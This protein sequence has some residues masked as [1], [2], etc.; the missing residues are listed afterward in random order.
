MRKVPA[1]FFTVALA[2][3]AGAAVF[4]SC[5]E[6]KPNDA[7]VAI[8][9]AEPTVGPEAGSQFLLVDAEGDWTVSVQDGCTWASLSKTSGSGSGN[10]VLS[11]E[12]N[13]TEGPRTCGIEARSAG[14]KYRSKAELL[15]QADSHSGGHENGKPDKVHPWMELPAVDESD[16][17]TDFFCHNMTVGKYNGRN[18]SFL[19]DY[20]AKVSRWVAYPLNKGLIGSGSRTNQWGLDPKLPSDRQPALFGGFS[21]GY[22][23][24]HQIPSADR[25]EYSANVSTFYFTNM[26]PQR[27]ELNEHA[28]ATLEGYVRNWSNKFDTLYVVTGADIAGSTEVAYDNNGQ[29]VCVPVGYFKALLGY[30]KGGTLGITGGT[31]GYTAIAF[32]FEHKSYSDAAIMST[33]AMTVDELELMTGYDFFVNLPSA[34]GSDMASKVESTR[35]VWWWNSQK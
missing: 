3:A 7:P 17:G 27:G 35:D 34:I 12:A 33:Q 8:S 24:G 4:L 11:W 21:G 14:G 20:G 26:T 2:M 22:Q 15:Q 29:E 9:V 30:K 25:L 16:S 28:W 13:D 6:E 19:Y 18:Y 32:Y 10:T 23:R 5:G 1:V 31:G